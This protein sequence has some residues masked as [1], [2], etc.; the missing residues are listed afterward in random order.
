MEES[1]INAIEKYGGGTFSY[2]KETESEYQTWEI[3]PSGI[4]KD[5]RDTFQ[6]SEYRDYEHFAGV[7]GKFIPELFLRGKK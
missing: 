7:M 1:T 5:K 6:K 4:K 3:Y 2:V